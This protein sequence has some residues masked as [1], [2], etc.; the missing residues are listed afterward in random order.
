ME[1]YQYCVVV[2]VYGNDGYW[3]D[4]EAVYVTREEATKNMD[5][6]KSHTDKI[7]NIRLYQMI[8]VTSK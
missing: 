8:P 2:S 5:E 3:R 7:M 4:I 1:D 6:A